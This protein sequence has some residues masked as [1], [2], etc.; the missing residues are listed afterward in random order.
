MSTKKIIENI[1]IEYKKMNSDLEMDCPIENN[2]FVRVEIE[3]T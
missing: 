1:Y 3:K 2:L